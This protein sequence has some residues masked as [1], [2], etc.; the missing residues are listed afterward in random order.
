VVDGCVMVERLFLRLGVLGESAEDGKR[1]DMATA[2]EV[3]SLLRNGRG[4]CCNCRPLQA[5]VNFLELG[6]SD[7]REASRIAR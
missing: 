6:D 1:K 2:L 5:H 3:P 4:C 7:N